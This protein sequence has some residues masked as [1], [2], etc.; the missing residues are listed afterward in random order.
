MLGRW[1]TYVAHDR[2]LTQRGGTFPLEADDT[3]LHSH[4]DPG[5]LGHSATMATP[6]SFLDPS[7]ESPASL[8]TPSLSSSPR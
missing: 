1:R 3:L 5:L 6:L 7:L 2:H 4:R 8:P